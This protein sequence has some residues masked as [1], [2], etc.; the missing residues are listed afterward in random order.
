MNNNLIQLKEKIE[1]KNNLELQ[2]KKAKAQLAEA[3]RKRADLKDRLKKEFKDVEQ[4]ENGGIT[5]LFYSILGSKE[6]KLDKERQEYLSAKLKYENAKSE[7][8][9]LEQEAERLST[10]M[11]AIGNPEKEYS[12]LLNAKQQQLQLKNDENYLEMNKKLGVFYSEKKEVA[13]AIAAGEKA[14]HG[15]QLAM[16]SLRKAQNWGTL[17]MI[18]GGLLTTA[19]KHSNID[20]AQSIIHN[21]QFQLKKFRRELSDVRLT[22]IPEL[23]VQLDSFSTFADY[24]F[25]NLI[26]DWVVQSKINR[27][28]ENCEHMYRQVST[29]ITQLKSSDKNITENYKRT[30]KALT[31]Y[32]EKVEL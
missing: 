22:H 3:K 5:S 10:E 4:L 28:M 2:L 9:T 12:Q 23:G 11:T 17:D 27:S 19:V 7:V 6:K 30:K 32:L 13:E 14:M 26:F 18:G 1:Q 29:I 25:D 15:L 21:V 16:H 24:F 20:D 8:E 31:R